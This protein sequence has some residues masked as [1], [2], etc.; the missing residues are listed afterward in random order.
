MFLF[1]DNSDPGRIVAAGIAN[2]KCVHCIYAVTPYAGPLLC[3]DKFLRK[4]HCRLTDLSGIAVRVG[5]GGFTAARVA[6]TAANTLAFAL[7]IPVAGVMGD[8]AGN[9][10]GVLAKAKAGRFAAPRYT[11]PAN[12]GPCKKKV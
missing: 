9:W 6:V 7:N 8:Y 3:V 11:A 5:E 10:S 4:V 1:L 12:V 2:N